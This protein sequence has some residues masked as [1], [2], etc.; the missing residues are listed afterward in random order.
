MEK[1]VLFFLK[2][3]KMFHL[4]DPKILPNLFVT[5]RGLFLDTDLNL[6]TNYNFVPYNIKLLY[7]N[8]LL[9]WVKLIIS[10]KKIFV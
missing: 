10:H 5:L 9:K 1:G 3:K 2:L 6:N 4:I 7:L 8:H